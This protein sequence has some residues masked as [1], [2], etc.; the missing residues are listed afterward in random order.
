MED[1]P[2]KKIYLYAFVIGNVIFLICIPTALLGKYLD[3]DLPDNFPNNIIQNIDNPII[4]GGFL[5]A[6][7]M[8]IVPFLFLAGIEHFQRRKKS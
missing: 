8:A 3:G 6:Y 2:I 5:I 1:I 4:Y 7:F